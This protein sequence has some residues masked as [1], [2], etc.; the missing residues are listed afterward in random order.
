MHQ[1]QKNLDEMKIMQEKEQQQIKNNQNEY[2]SILNSNSEES[3]LLE[4]DIYV[5]SCKLKSI[6]EENHTLKNGIDGLEKGI[7]D[8][9]QCTEEGKKF[10][11]SIIEEL[12]ETRRKL[13]NSFKE[14]TLKEET[15]NWRDTEMMH[16]LS[17]VLNILNHNSK[18]VNSVAEQLFKQL[19]GLGIY[20]DQVCNKRSQ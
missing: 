5:Q 19:E 7:V 8:T 15:L 1:T 13:T 14:T 16:Q 3:K 6:I 10:H 9:D 4:E 18:Q 2:L 11:Q 12:V 17:G 20:L